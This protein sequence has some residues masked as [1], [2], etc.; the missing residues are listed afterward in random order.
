MESKIKQ[1][2]LNKIDSLNTQI[3]TLKD[4]IYKECRYYAET[5]GKFKVGDVV[6]R[7]YRVKT[8]YFKV[9]S[10]YY[11]I[12]KNQIIYRVE[13]LTN[14]KR[15]QDIEEDYL[16]K[17]L[18]K[19]EILYPE[20]H[21]SGNNSELPNKKYI[22]HYMKSNPTIRHKETADYF[23]VPYSTI[24]RYAKEN[25]I[26]KNAK[27]EI[28]K[29]VDYITANPKASIKKIAYDLGISVMSVYK[30]R[31]EYNLPIKLERYR[32]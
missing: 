25:G 27:I 5:H 24:L 20:F 15:I 8:Y 3:T 11:S 9:L 14:K 26:H 1:E 12:S 16:K 7:E 29:L 30:C 13:L 2:F 6:Y 10:Y 28:P 4:N 18:L 22:I 17:S 32:T 31:V 21:K 23:K 19:E